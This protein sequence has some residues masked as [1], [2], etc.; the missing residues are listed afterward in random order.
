MDSRQLVTRLFF[1]FLIAGGLFWHYLLVHQDAPTLFSTFMP[2]IAGGLV[3]VFVERLMPARA[4]WWPRQRD[5]ITDSS[6]LA[7]V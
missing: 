4:Q 1:P 2:I 3:I 6:F 7:L 5:V